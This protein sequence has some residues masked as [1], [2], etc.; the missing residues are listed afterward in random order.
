MAG[1]TGEG[2]ASYPN[3]GSSEV[4]TIWKRYLKDEN[5]EV[6]EYKSIIYT[7]ISTLWKSLGRLAP[8]FSDV[9]LLFFMIVKFNCFSFLRKKGG[10]IL[11]IVTYEKYRNY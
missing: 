9:E 1:E 7:L 8:F 4:L 6:V 5:G 11:L 2:K 3:P 10:I